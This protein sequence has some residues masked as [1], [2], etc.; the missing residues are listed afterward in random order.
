MT[1]LGLAILITGTAGAS[2]NFSHLVD[3]ASADY[4]SRA[5]AASSEGD[6]QKGLAMLKVLLVP[7]TNVRVDYSGLPA[8]VAAEFRQGVQSG[9]KMWGDA[10]GSDM[11]FS[12]TDR[13]EAQVTIRFV[14]SIH[15]H[16][17]QGVDCKGEI[18]ARRR[19]Q[20]G[21]DVHYF[22]FAAQISI[23]RFREGRTWM[24]SGEIAHITAHELGHALGLGDVQ[25]S[26]RIMGPMT[27]G[28]PLSALTQDEVRA[29]QGFR[30]SVRSEIERVQSRANST[31]MNGIRPRIG[32]PIP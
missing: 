7:R 13:P 15:G 2:A 5:L 28:R 23:V 11:P 1:V 27:L 25:Q 18:T 6:H 21:P 20:W 31:G 24:S 14:D 22:E 8:D 30:A 29:V 4:F 10:L 26:G 3:N 9:L 19:I 16:S 12:L 32:I 17:H